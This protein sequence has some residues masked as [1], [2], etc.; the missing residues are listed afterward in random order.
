MAI[1]NNQLIKINEYVDDAEKIIQKIQD[2]HLN[3]FNYVAKYL[4]NWA[5]GANIGQESKAKFDKLNKTLTDLTIIN[6]KFDDVIYNFCVKQ[7]S[8]NMGK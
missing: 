6:K 8:Y 2:Y 5:D 4:Q 1:A 7:R 3:T